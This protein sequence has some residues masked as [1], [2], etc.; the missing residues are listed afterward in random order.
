VQSVNLLGSFP[1]RK[2]F[3][4]SICDDEFGTEEGYKCHIEFRTEDLE[5]GR[6]FSWNVWVERAP[7]ADDEGEKTRP[8]ET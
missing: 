4:D 7:D 6:A 2:E 1:S 3:N 8:S 5:I